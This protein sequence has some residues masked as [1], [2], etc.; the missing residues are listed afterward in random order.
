[1]TERVPLSPEERAKLLEKYGAKTEL[2]AAEHSFARILLLGPAKLGKT[3]ALLETA[4]DV[5]HI[6]CD[7][8]SAPKFAKRRGA[9]FITVEAYNR[10]G[11]TKAVKG[12]KEMVGAGIVRTVL[13]DSITLLAENV[14]RE[15]ENTLQGHDLWREYGKFLYRVQKDLSDLPA[16]LFIVGHLGAKE[17]FEPGVLPCV[18]GSSKTK[19]P[20]AVDD[21]II[22]DFEQGRKPHER[23][24]LVGPQ[25]GWNAGGRS[26]KR[27]T[28]TEATVPALFEELGL[29]L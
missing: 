14:L 29:S 16:H 27:T 11:V 20:A 10:A 8:S 7:G 6:N 24:F 28:T 12:A 13:L 9:K 23:A 18:P 1:M 26:V 2:D 4:P 21:W 25:K 5:Y 19:I 17:D 22:F 3:T 15:M